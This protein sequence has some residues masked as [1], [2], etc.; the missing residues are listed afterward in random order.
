MQGVN[1]RHPPGGVC[2][3]SGELLRYQPSMVS[4][5]RLKVPGGSAMLPM[6]GMLVAYNINAALRTMMAN[7]ALQ[8]AW[9]MGDDHTYAP[10]LLLNLLDRDVDVVVPLCLNRSPPMLPTISVDDKRL[11]HMDELPAGGLYK[12]QPNETTGDAGMLI[13]R[14]VLEALGSD[15]YGK[16]KSGGHNS[17]DREF[18]EKVKE[19]GFDVHVDLDNPIGHMT[20][21]ELWPAR[22]GNQWVIRCLSAGKHM[23]D[24]GEIQ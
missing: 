24:L 13:R 17:E 8:W 12:L 20:G 16:R 10:D 4:F 2:L 21:I 14:N 7:P 9:L 1:S 15:W 6:A 5:M 3:I 11:K 18:V 22:D 23:C 19:A